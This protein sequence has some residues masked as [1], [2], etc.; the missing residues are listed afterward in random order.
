MLLPV[1][2]ETER[3]TFVGVGDESGGA[4]HGHGSVPVH[5]DIHYGNHQVD[6]QHIFK[7]KLK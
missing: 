5:L 2:S 3:N 4:V 1:E 6:E 7:T